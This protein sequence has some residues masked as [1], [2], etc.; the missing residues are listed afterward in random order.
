MLKI[1]F[2]EHELINEFYWDIEFI[3]SE[4]IKGN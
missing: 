4:I 3:I 1:Y 2:T